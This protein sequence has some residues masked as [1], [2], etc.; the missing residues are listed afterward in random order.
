[1]TDWKVSSLVAVLLTLSGC[2]SNPLMQTGRATQTD[3]AEAAAHALGEAMQTAPIPASAVALPAPVA[4]AL[5]PPIPGLTGGI[6][7]ERFDVQVRDIPAALFF[8]GLMDG[9][10]YNAVVHP[11]VQ[12]LISLSLRQVSVPEVMAMLADMYGFDIQR[13][14]RLFKILPGGLQTRVFEIDYLHMVRSGGSETQVSSGQVSAS[15]SG[16]NATAS[17]ETPADRT[18]GTRITT[19]TE[20]DFWGQLDRTL[21]LIVGG[22]EGRQ[23][24]TTPGAGIVVVRALPAELRAVET[25]LDRA[26]LTLRR[27]VILEAKIL[28]VALN[29]GY[30]QG[31]DWSAVQIFSA[32]PDEQGFAKKY[33][34]GRLTGQTVE[35][36]DPALGGVFSAALRI[37]DFNALI[38]LLG[39]QGNVQV[40]SSP[41]ISTLNNQKAVIK[42]GTDEFFVTDI[43][44]DENTTTTAT[45]NSTTASVELTPFFSGISLDVTPQI[46]QDGDI[47][48]HV[49]PSVSE[50]VDQ[51]KIITIGDRDVTLPLALST[52]RETDSVI[53][54]RNGQ[55]VVIGGLIQ[56]TSEDK[57]SSVPLLGDIPLLGELFKQKRSQSRKSEL[58]ILLR[59]MLTG[60]EA[61]QRDLA[62]SEARMQA[63]KSLLQAPESPLP[64]PA[65]RGEAP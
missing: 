19:S 26:S 39:T 38:S 27:Q 61:W 11:D 8:Q 34:N 40:L 5:L 28:E 23:V 52:V 54:A 14:D 1:M 42:V 7:D 25:Y 47:T 33:L 6:A 22:G 18:I 31:V 46:G 13:E 12:G 55:V 64:E 51:K 37:S 60:D 36:A 21:E 48:L 59:P 56:N 9:T 57:N 53:R 45:S 63:L 35:N 44:F 41:R 32:L 4:Q 50:V 2:A 16:G 17:A 62:A 10:G 49:H 43:E 30:Q 24:V 29:E 58:V 3:A 20:S 65:R 15:R